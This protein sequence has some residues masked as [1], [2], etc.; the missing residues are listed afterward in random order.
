MARRASAGG[1]SF[2]RRGL[3][4]VAAGAGGGGGG[5]AA[6]RRP[7]VLHESMLHG[8]HL[9]V[10]TPGSTLRSRL[11]KTCRRRVSLLY[12]VPV[13]TRRKEN[14]AG[15]GGGR[16][17]KRDEESTGCDGTRREGRGDPG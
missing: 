16:R 6:G 12:T 11:M 3:S 1:G 9:K 14:T 10:G 17:M 5:G 15:G 8:T 4:E 2:P 7:V 13:S